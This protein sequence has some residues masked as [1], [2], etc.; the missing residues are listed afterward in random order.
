MTGLFRDTPRDLEKRIDRLVEHFRH[1]E[2]LFFLNNPRGLPTPSELLWLLVCDAVRTAQHMPD[3]ERRMVSR[4]GSAMPS[5]RVTIDQAYEVE[6]SRLLD[7]SELVSRGLP[8]HTSAPIREA[9]NQSDADRMVDVL[10]LLRFVV[11]GRAGKDALRMKRVVLAR[12]AGL[13]L[14]QCGRV[15]DKHRLNFD[16]RSMHDIKSRVLGQILGNIE[17][18]FGLIR[19]SRGFRRLTV[20]EIER[21]RKERKRAERQ[22]QR[23]E[24]AANA[25]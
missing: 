15:W 16:R 18:E 22:R 2:Y 11:G 3:V 23:E 10:D 14:E 7:N 12:A 9:V 1:A 20:R 24:A 4:V 25:D 13:S 19:T 21:R 17:K 6:L 5:A 8:K